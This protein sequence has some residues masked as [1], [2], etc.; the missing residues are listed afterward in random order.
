MSSVTN[1]QKGAGGARVRCA[2]RSRR[3]FAPPS[4]PA[5]LRVATLQRSTGPVGQRIASL[6]RSARDKRRKA[7]PP[8]G[9]SAAIAFHKDSAAGKRGVRGAEPCASGVDVPIS[10]RT[11]NISHHFPRLCTHANTTIVRLS[12]TRAWTSCFSANF[13]MPPNPRPRNSIRACSPATSLRRCGHGS[14]PSAVAAT[15]SHSPE[16]G[17]RSNDWRPRVLRIA[18]TRCGRSPR[19]VVGPSLALSPMAPLSGT[20]GGHPLVEEARRSGRMDH[21]SRPHGRRLMNR[22]CGA[23]SRPRWPDAA[24][25][26]GRPAGNTGLHT[27]QRTGG[28]R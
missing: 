2:T 20:R 27:D 16:R 13:G 10:C 6:G 18:S 14:R 21:D 28:I 8:A 4:A 3:G 7:V 5:A 19:R 26:T 17:R 11:G 9:Q 25:S 1:Q 12:P 23:D 15:P 24:S 22:G